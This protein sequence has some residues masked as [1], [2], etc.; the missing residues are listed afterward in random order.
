MGSFSGLLILAFFGLQASSVW[1]SVALLSSRASSEPFLFSRPG[2]LFSVSGA[3][4]GLLCLF[5]AFSRTFGLLGFSAG[6]FLCVLL[7]S[8]LRGLRF[9]LIGLG[10]ILFPL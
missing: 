6:L 10:E 5:C 7:G 9:S 8:F 3:F 2:L 1:V 4:L